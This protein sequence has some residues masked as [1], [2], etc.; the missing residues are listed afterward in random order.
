MDIR[1]YTG[2]YGD[3]RW[4]TTEYFAN[5]YMIDEHVPD[6]IKHGEAL[7]DLAM[8][9]MGTSPRCLRN[10]IGSTLWLFIGMMIDQWMKFRNGVSDFETKPH[11][12]EL[13]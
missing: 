13:Q 7:P 2:T 1:G 11:I 4:P 3:S 6:C 8:N 10:S 9:N 12:C 5:G